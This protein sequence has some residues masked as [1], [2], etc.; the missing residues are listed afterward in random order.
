MANNDEY[1][2]GYQKKSRIKIALVDDHEMFREG[3][4]ILIS[5][6]PEFDLTGAVADGREMKRLIKS[7]QPDVV[8]MDVKLVAEDG[9]TLTEFIKNK[10]PDISVVALT[11]ND[12]PNTI[13]KMLSAGA[14]GY[15]L[16]NA[17]KAELKES[18]LKVLD[19]EEYYSKEAAFQV[20]NK[21]SQK[22]KKNIAGVELGGFSLREIQIIRLICDGRTNIEIAD[23]L[24]LSTRTVEKHRFNIMKRMNAKT[25]AELAVY[26][27]RHNLLED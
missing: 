19:G 14:S 3:L 16:K 20:I 22:E 13:L 23:K 10:Y 11:M 12:N 8:F 18:V 1:S 21:I 15:L 9:I 26:A 5:Q 7:E 17:T 2:G 24:H 27:M 4:G 6:I 25:A